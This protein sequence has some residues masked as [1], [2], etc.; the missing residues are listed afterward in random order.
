MKTTTSV[1]PDMERVS[2]RLASRR[3]WSVE[4][5]DV[6]RYALVCARAET[7][8]HRR[9]KR[10]TPLTDTTNDRRTLGNPASTWRD[11]WRPDRSRSGTVRGASRS[12]KVASALPVLQ[13]IGSHCVGKP[14]PFTRCKNMHAVSIAPWPAVHP[15]T[16]LI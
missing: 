3:V 11:F 7:K 1:Q 15:A 16:S 8:A 4:T 9:A 13:R 10:M 12:N 6:V 5:G 2:A 14:Y